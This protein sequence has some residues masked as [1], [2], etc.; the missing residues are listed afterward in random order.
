MSSRIFITVFFNSSFSLLFC[1]C[2]CF[3]LSSACNSVIINCDL[4]SSMA[5]AI[6]C[7]CW[8]SVVCCCEL[9]PPLGPAGPTGPA[10]PASAS[11]ARTP[12]TPCLAEKELLLLCLISSSSSLWAA[13][14]SSAAAVCADSLCSCSVDALSCDASLCNSASAM[15]SLSCIC[16]CSWLIDCTRI[17]MRVCSTSSCSD[18]CCACCCCSSDSLRASPRAI[19]CRDRLC[20]DSA[21]TSISRLSP[22]ICASFSKKRNTVTSPR[23]AAPAPAPELSAAPPIPNARPL[24]C[25]EELPK[26]WPLRL[27]ASAASACFFCCSCSPAT[28]PLLASSFSAMPSRS[29]SSNRIRVSSSLRCSSAAAF[30]PCAASAARLTRS[31]SS[32]LSSRICFIARTKSSLAAANCACASELASLSCSESVW[33]WSANCCSSCAARCRC[34]RS[35]SKCDC[36]SFCV[37]CMRVVSSLFCI[38]S[39]SSSA[40]R[41][42]LP[43]TGAGADPS[44]PPGPTVGCD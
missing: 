7:S 37:L 42:S 31:S 38:F 23:A 5:F 34:V 43:S 14:L 24:S 18:I 44:I 9:R 21:S 28:S 39:T 10:G 8:S 26:P 16:T 30:S 20:R 32:S 17:A 19:S 33:F 29:C 2:I 36:D 27:P 22:L 13:M 4:R 35:R 1:S 15:D 3:S 25:L 6:C 12:P 11:T 41:S 40:S